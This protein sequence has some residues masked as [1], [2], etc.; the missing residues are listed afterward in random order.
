[1]LYNDVNEFNWSAD[2]FGTTYTDAAFGTS[3]TTGAANTKGSAVSAISGASVTEDCYALSL[4]FTGGY[5]SGGI[6]TYLVDLLIDPA[7]GTSWST[8]IENVMADSPGFGVGGVFYNFP[9]FI[10][11]G[12]SIGFQAQCNAATQTLRCGVILHGKPTRPDLMKYG[13]KVTTYGAN[14]TTTSGVAITTGASQ[15][16]GSWTSIGTLS[17][18]HW[19]WQMGFGVQDS[20]AGASFQYFMDMS[21]GDGTNQRMAMMDVSYF[22]TSSEIGGMMNNP[23]L[24]PVRKGNSGE[25]V[26]IRALASYAD[27]SGLV[28]TAYGVS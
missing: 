11:S 28:A 18:D 25:G 20:T 10:K 21:I 8:L 27:D 16:K 19:A 7:G 17:S 24:Q 12:T 4:V 14:T 26:Y 2:N 22:K 13:H 23:Y 1:M 3:I 5:S 15:T 6:R 9:I